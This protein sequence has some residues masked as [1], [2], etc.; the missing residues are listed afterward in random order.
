MKTILAPVLLAFLTIG[1]GS[2]G[3]SPALPGQ[4]ADVSRHGSHLLNETLLMGD[5]WAEER[6]AGSIPAERPQGTTVQD[7]RSSVDGIPH[8]WDLGEEAANGADVAVLG[9]MNGDSAIGDC[10]PCECGET[11][12]E[13][14][15]V[16][17]GCQGKECGDDGCGGSCGDEAPCQIANEWGT[18][19]GNLVCHEG[20][21]TDCDAPVPGPEVC[22]GVDRCRRTQSSVHPVVQE[23]RYT[24][25]HRNTP[26]GVGGAPNMPPNFSWIWPA[27]TV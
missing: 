13:G 16:F 21:W 14:T 15:C 5:E 17:V 6:S 7:S 23:F 10:G 1:C 8:W 24:S 25:M 22:D 20:Q 9:D 26:A 19:L 27:G 11:C 4:V 12:V 3:R 2:I 18:C